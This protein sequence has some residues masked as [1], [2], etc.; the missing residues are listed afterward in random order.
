[1]RPNSLAETCST[2]T[3]LI[4]LEMAGIWVIGIFED[5]R[6]VLFLLRI[7]IQTVRKKTTTMN[8]PKEMHTTC[9]TLRRKGPVGWERLSC[10]V[11]DDEGASIV[12]RA[13]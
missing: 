13:S 1:M 7:V 11:G 3:S 2:L 4:S 9:Q 8:T 5:A 12:D 10:R 6:L